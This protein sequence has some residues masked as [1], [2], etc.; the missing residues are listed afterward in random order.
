MEKIKLSWSIISSWSA[1]R[2][3]DAIKMF[4]GGNIEDNEYLQEGRRLHKLISDKK[5][6]LLPIIKDTAIFEDINPEEHKWVNYFRVPVFDWLE[7][8]M[9]ADVLDP[10]EGLLIDWKTGSRK[11]TQHNKLQLYIYAYLLTKLE[12]PIYIKSAILAKVSEDVS[13]AVICD[14][15]SLFSIDDNKLEIAENYIES[16]ASEI[17]NFIQEMNNGK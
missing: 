12:Q 5:L 13:G 15:F 7:M 4:M 9:V 10:V 3:D 8:S 1:G 16:N 14:D 2:R 6:R 11:S 17:F